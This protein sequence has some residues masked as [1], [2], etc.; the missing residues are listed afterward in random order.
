M[1]AFPIA[2]LSKALQSCTSAASRSNEADEHA[3]TTA[4]HGRLA[5]TSPTNATRTNAS[6]DA[7][8]RRLATTSTAD[9]TGATDATADGEHTY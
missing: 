4:E 9:A 2:Y 8:R 5:A 7:R 6:A 1:L 3:A